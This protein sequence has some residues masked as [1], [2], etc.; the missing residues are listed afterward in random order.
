MKLLQGQVAIITGASRGI[1]R[2]IAL[3]LATQGATI[4]VNYANS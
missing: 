2:A 1:G 4:I 3:E